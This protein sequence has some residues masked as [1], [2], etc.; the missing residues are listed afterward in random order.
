MQQFWQVS[1][2]IMD[3]DPCGVENK[4]KNKKNKKQSPPSFGKMIRY[5]VLHC[6]HRTL[7]VLFPRCFSST[8]RCKHIWCTQRFV[9]RHRHG[10]THSASRSSSSDAK[11]TQHVLHR[12]TNMQTYTITCVIPLHATSHN[13]RQKM[14]PLKYFCH[15]LAI[16]RNFEVKFYTFI[17]SIM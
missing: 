9:P 4:N 5:S 10:L 7:A 6:G 1:K 17:T 15:F 3:Q 2:I 11:Q 12:H 14:Y 16:I 8:Q 13:Q